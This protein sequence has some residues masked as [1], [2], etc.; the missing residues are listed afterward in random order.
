M[1]KFS[2]KGETPPKTLVRAS[3]FLQIKKELG[4]K[5]LTGDHLVL[6]GT[7]ALDVPCLIRMGVST[8]HISVVEYNKEHAAS[9]QS[10]NPFIPIQV[11]NVFDYAHGKKY[12]S[13]MLDFCSNLTPSMVRDITTM[14][15]ESL[16][17]GSVLGLTLRA[18]RESGYING[19]VQS[20]I[21]ETQ[22]SH[23][24]DSI[25]FGR[26][27]AFHKEMSNLRT[28]KGVEHLC[29]Y[30]YVSNTADTNGN[31]MVTSVWRVV[32]GNVAPPNPHKHV[33]LD[34]TKKYLDDTFKKKALEL[35]KDSPL[36]PWYSILNIP[37]RTF[38]GWKAHDG[39]G[40][41]KK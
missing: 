33:D 27:L 6:A 34:S 36:L 39:M 25:Y 15:G 22:H 37:L 12:I 21:V 30:G 4:S 38:A 8:T 1:S 31:A 26:V 9:A 7:H 17:V 13:A 18:G 24:I 29:S 41:Y 35:W 32:K 16:P 10:F 3:C 5:F 20:S 19:A 2:Y 23:G 28:D 14:V 11:S 40:T